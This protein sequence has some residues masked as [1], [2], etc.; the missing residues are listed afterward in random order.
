[1]IRSSLCQEESGI[2]PPVT[3]VAFNGCRIA[4][5]KHI[6]QIK[7]N[8]QLKVVFDDLHIYERITL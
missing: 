5:K 1:M 3:S 2:M 6:Q 4:R 7:D 8:Y